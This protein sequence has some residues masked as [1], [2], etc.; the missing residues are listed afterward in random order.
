MMSNGNSFG[1]GDS[2]STGKTTERECPFIRRL[3]QVTE[4]R[5]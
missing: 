1:N 4:R 2:I 5:A 3:L